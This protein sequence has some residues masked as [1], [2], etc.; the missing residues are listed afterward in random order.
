MIKT[1]AI[2]FVRQILVQTLYEENLKDTHFLGGDNQVRIASFYEQL[3]TQDEVDRFVETYRDIVDQQNRTGL[4]ANGIIVSPENP[5]ITNIY[6][7]TIIP[8]TWTCSLRTTLGD[9]D[10]VILTINNLIEQLKGRKIDIAELKTQD[11]FGKS[12]TKLFKV[13]TISEGSD[14]LTI[15]NGDYIGSFSG[16]INLHNEITTIISGL[17]SKGFTNN[18]SWLYFGHSETTTN[19][20]KVAY[21]DTSSNTWKAI[22][23]DGE[24]DDIIFPPE[25]SD[26]KKWKVSLSFESIRCDEPRTLNSEEYCEITFGGSATIVNNGVAL[27]NDLTKITIQKKKILANTNIT[28]QNATKYYLEPLEL[29]SG[30]NANTTINQLVS[31]KLINNTH[32]DAINLSIQYSFVLDRNNAL[33]DQFFLYGRYGTQGITASDISPN[34]IFEIVEVWSSWGVVNVVSYLAKVVEEI[35]IE[36]TEGDTLTIGIQFQIQGENN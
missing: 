22:E 31:N 11:D 5:T 8:L 10:Y 33:L 15:E 34:M 14:T 21:F 29:P 3:K 23:D 18:A 20:I 4:I 32:T 30:N 26:F 7:A 17:T 1:F 24:H 36:N 27:G 13:G 9:R 12:I 28:F 35:S 6:S 16:T 19:K 25:H 2:E